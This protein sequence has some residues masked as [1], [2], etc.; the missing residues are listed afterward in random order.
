M[1][2]SMDSP[3]D[4]WMFEI[5]R[6][7]ARRRLVRVIDETTLGS[8]ATWPVDALLDQ[9]GFDRDDR[10]LCHHVH[11]AK[12][13]VADVIDWDRNGDIVAPGPSFPAIARLVHRFETPFL[14]PGPSLS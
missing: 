7:P 9:A 3:P 14:Q 13:A 1:T 12:L 5:L 6:H 8:D 10:I 4:G 2:M 11:L